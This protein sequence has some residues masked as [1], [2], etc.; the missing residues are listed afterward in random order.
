MTSMPTDSDNNPIPALRL[1][2][3]AA[4][5]IAAGTSAGRN[6]IP[7]DSKTKVVSVYTTQPVF[8]KFGDQN[9][10]A[11]S[12]DHFYPTGIY[13]DFAIGGDKVGHATHLS[14]IRADTTDAVVYVS[15]KY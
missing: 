7:F 8:L 5:A 11:T 14:A 10:Q 15:E 9:V 6:T 1:R 3:D 12:A 4:H 13:Y 2:P